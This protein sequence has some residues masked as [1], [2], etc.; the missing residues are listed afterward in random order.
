MLTHA[1]IILHLNVLFIMAPLS[2]IHGCVRLQ[3]ICYPTGRT[4]YV[5]MC[6]QT[7]L[8]WPSLD[9]RML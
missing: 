8:S 1:Y 3:G 9:V 2:N 6:R 7:G 4:A 5:F